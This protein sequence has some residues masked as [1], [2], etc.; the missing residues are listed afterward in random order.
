[1]ERRLSSRLLSSPPQLFSASLP[2]LGR[3]A[4]TTRANAAGLC[5]LAAW[6]G[7]IRFITP[8]FLGTPPPLPHMASSD[9]G[10]VLGTCGPIVIAKCKAVDA[11]GWND[12]PRPMRHRDP[13]DDPPAKR[14][15]QQYQGPPVTLG[16]IRSHGV[17]HLLIYCS[18]GLYCHHSA[19]VDADRWP[20]EIV[21]LDLDAKAV[22][23]KCGI[24]GA[25]VRPNWRERSERASLTGVQQ[26]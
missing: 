8:E 13:H 26:R 24:I 6:T 12:W 4:A 5:S 10:M 15:R 2:L 9:R 16:H 19:V 25:D 23:T 20:D 21:L 1:V 7:S 18:E 11:I 22:C 3:P 14:P 17:R